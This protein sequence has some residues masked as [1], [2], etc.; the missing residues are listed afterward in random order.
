M[1][2]PDFYGVV[3]KGERTRYLPTLRAARISAAKRPG[4]IIAV[5]E[6]YSRSGGVFGNGGSVY[7]DIPLI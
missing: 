2:K 3:R 6:S 7:R 5:L 1:R 4:R